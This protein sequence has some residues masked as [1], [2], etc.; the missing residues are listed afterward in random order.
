MMNWK[1]LLLP[2]R[3]GKKEEDQISIDDRSQFQRDYD[4]IIFSAPFRRLQNKTQV[5]PLPGSVFVHNRLTHS[6][7]VA[8]IGRSLAHVVGQQL[9]KNDFISDSEMIFDM[10]AIVSAAC[11]AHDLGNPPFGHS[12]EDAIRSYFTDL[13]PADLKEKVTHAQWCDWTRF[14]GNANAFRSLSH[15]FNGRREGGFALTYASLAA[16]VKY[17]YGADSKEKKY[18]FFQ[19]EKEIFRNIADAVGLICLDELNLTYTRHPLVY[20]VE[21][22]DDIAYLIMDIEDA[23][24]LHIIDDN[25]VWELLSPF[26][27]HNVPLTN[28]IHSNFKVVTDSNEQVA[29]LRSVVIN[30]LVQ[31]SAQVFIQHHD[32]IMNGIFDGSLIQHLSSHLIDALDVCRKFSVK[33][34]YNHRSVVEVE[35]TGFNVLRALLAEF[36]P[37]ALNYETAYN[38]KLMALV[39][40]QFR[41][42][43]EDEY[44]KVQSILDFISGMTDLYA[45]ELYR[46]IKGI[47]N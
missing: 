43:E 27:A 2:R 36:V 38:R 32:D 1:Q 29:Y 6:L 9:I 44:S 18:G 22:A 11:L 10:Q 35:L 26:F 31:A 20:L 4:R 46:T 30:Q 42:N 39:P 7:E 19:T 14:E 15:Q 25:K 23:H 33:E 40:Q 41:Y 17:P 3:L 8:S 28:S 12:G 47:G 21:A 24:R 16:I 45:I 37:A 34:I 5:F 13:A